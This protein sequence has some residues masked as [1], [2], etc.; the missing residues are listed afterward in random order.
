TGTVKIID[1]GSTRV[2]GIMEITTPIE[3]T[4]LLGTAQYTAPEYFL[5]ESG[6]PRSDM[7]SLGVITYQMLTG[8]LP[9]GTQVAKSRTKAAQNKLNYH[10]VLHD[11][12]EL[13]AWIDEA[14][15]KVVHPNP[16]KRYEELSEFIY[17]LRH[18]NKAF[19]NKTRPPLMESNP[20]LFWKSVSFILTVIIAMLLI[21]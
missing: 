6:T 13:P 9:Y 18:P 12:R 3:R 5:G 14:L 20:V 7:F 16:Y 1:F 19:L 21:R 4:D 11:E 2:A 17:D 15:R 8:K 10:S